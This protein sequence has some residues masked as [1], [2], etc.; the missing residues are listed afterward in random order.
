M[1]THSFPARVASGSK[2]QATGD[3]VDEHAEATGELDEGVAAGWQ[4][5]VREPEVDDGAGTNVAL[6]I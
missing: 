5:R 2:N 3:G 1:V 4:A 6:R